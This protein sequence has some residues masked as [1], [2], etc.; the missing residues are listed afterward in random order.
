MARPGLQWVYRLNFEAYKQG[1]GATCGAPAWRC[2]LET[3]ELV[4]CVVD[5]ALERKALDVVVL[6][7]R[8]LSSYAEY[9]VVASG[10]SDRHVQAVAENIDTTA[11]HRGS[12]CMGREGMREGQWALVDF[13]DVVVHVFHQFTRSVFDIENLWRDAPRRDIPSETASPELE[14]PPMWAPSF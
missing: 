11:G 7:V 10:S 12:H 14:A 3:S 5:A 8:G 13:G 1:L 2:T 6:D 9:L 4:Q